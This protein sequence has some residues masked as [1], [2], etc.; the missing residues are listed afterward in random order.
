MR[1]IAAAF[2]ALFAVTTLADTPQSST[3]T[4]PLDQYQL[5]QK[6]KESVSATVIDTM[7]LGGTFKDR[8]LTVSFTGRSVGARTATNVISDAS[9][10][11]L[12]GCSGDALMLR[13][14]KGAYQIVA[15]APA[16]TLRCDVR[17]SGSDRLP[18]SVQPSVLAI[19]S[20]VGD[21]EL[22]SGEEQDDGARTYT[23]VRQ[24]IGTN[25]TLAATATGRYLITLLP[26]AT[27]FRYVIQVHNP[28]RNTSPLPLH[29]VSGEHLQQ[30]D[31]AAPY[32][33]NAGSYV[34]AMPP[35]DS[36]ITLSGELKGTSF[37]PPVAASLQYAVIESHPLLRPTLQSA[38][39]RVSTGET[40]VETQYRGALAFEMGE[41]ERI[42]WSVT[43]LE[44]MRAISYAVKNATHT[45]FIPAKGPILGESEFQLDNQGA[46]E[47]MLPQ[48]PEPT[49]VSLQ[50]E[51]VLMTKNAAG[52]LTVPLSA[53]EQH[54]VVQYRQEAP[55]FGLLIGSLD[56][57]R[58][59]V[60]ATNTHVTV[61]YP[62]HWLPLWQS[63]ATEAKVWRPE[64]S[65]LLAF[66]LLALWIERVLAFLDV[67]GRARIAIALLLAF[68]GGIVPTV[69]WISVLGCAFITLVWLAANRPKW[70]P[71]RIV[72]AVIA[73][74]LVLV[75]AFAYVASK[76][77]GSNYESSSANVATDTGSV[78]REVAKP[79]VASPTEQVTTR[80][81]DI[82]SLAYQ[83]LPARF[84][85]PSGARRG[86][87][88]EQLLAA[89]RPQ[90]ITI[91]LLSMTIV[92]WTSIVMSL[93]AA[94]LLW[95]QR[96]EIRATLRERI[97][98]ARTLAPVTA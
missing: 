18:M 35:G 1:S 48:K 56:V 72:G 79:A 71:M 53:G 82:S 76:N 69:L 90:T 34:F 6:S 65:E 64:G 63:F 29:L 95:R 17:L 83:G 80:K 92:T 40:G 31:S 67:R 20:A 44:A 88:R 46:P 24:V 26:D 3:V 22:V 4:L 94:W 21:G 68:A 77:L 51:P 96:A 74:A 66:L 54:V 45:L 25:E 38:P 5:L 97:A 28:N 59:P 87:F 49:F 41:K 15:L 98:S 9:D 32:E 60:P 37:A 42:S 19:R 58:V 33:V 52:Q 47:L 91:V 39:K 10:V 57:P 84:E 7:T 89:D 70:T 36:T 16:F 30:I 2:L 43:R 27:R 55:Q 81:E 8:N 50:D 78:S 85:L 12:S 73:S 75:V 23:L 93:I 14:G 13:S 86:E 61:R 62:D 11:T